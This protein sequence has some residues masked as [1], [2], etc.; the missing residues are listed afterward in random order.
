MEC[1]NTVEAISSR[2]RQMHQALGKNPLLIGID[3]KGGSGKSTL[4]ARL[5]ETYEDLQI[6]EVDDFYLPE[7]MR[8]E[9]AIGSNFDWR[10]LREQVLEPLFHARVTEY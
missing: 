2:L 9:E 4:A 6:V 3:G 1:L 10:R 7:S 8:G 5:A